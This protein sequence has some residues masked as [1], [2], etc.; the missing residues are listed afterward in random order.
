M[1]PYPFY[2][3]G[4]DFIGPINPRSEGCTLILVAIELFTKWVEAVAMKKATGSSM[5]NFFEGKYN[6]SFWDNK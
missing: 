5:A 3:W 2:S 1:A 6:I 4:L